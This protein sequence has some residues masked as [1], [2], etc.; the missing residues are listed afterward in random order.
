MSNIFISDVQGSG[1]YSVPASDAALAS[2]TTGFESLL[3]GISGFAYDRVLAWVETASGAGPARTLNCVVEKF[4]FNGEICPSATE[5]YDGAGNGISELIDN[6][7]LGDHGGGN[8][9]TGVDKQ[10]YS[11]TNVAAEFYW[12][13]EFS[14]GFVFPTTTTDD[15]AVGGSSP[16][17]KWFQDGDLVLGGSAMSGTEKLRVVGDVRLDGGMLLPDAAAAPV[18]VSAGQGLFWS[19]DD[20]PNIPKFT[21]DSDTAY[22]LQYEVTSGFSLP[23]IDQVLFVDFAAKPYAGVGT[24][25]GPFNTI[26]E[27]VTAASALSPSASNRIGIVIYPGTYEDNISTTDDYVSFIGFARDSTIIR[28]TTGSTDV[29]NINNDNIRFENLTFDTTGAHTGNVA[30]FDTA[31]TDPTVFVNC[32]FEVCDADSSGTAFVVSADCALEFYDCRFLHVDTTDLAFY[33]SSGSGSILFENCYAQG[34]VRFSGTQEVF[35]SDSSLISGNSSQTVYADSGSSVVKFVHC[36]IENTNSAG[37]C[38]RPQSTVSGWEF[39]G[40][41]MMAGS[42]GYDIGDTTNTITCSVKNTTMQRGMNENCITLNPVKYVGSADDQDF[43]NTLQDAIDSIAASTPSEIILL[44]DVAVTSSLTTGSSQDVTIDGQGRQFDITRATGTV[45]TVS[46]GSTFEL[47]EVKV[48]G[49][50]L[51]DD[52]DSELIVNKGASGSAALQYDVFSGTSIDFDDVYLQ[53]TKVFHGSLGSN[54]PFTG[55]GTGGTPP[56]CDYAAHD[57]CFN[58]EPDVADSTYLNNTIASAQR[59]NT[60]DVN[61]D[62][63]WL[64]DF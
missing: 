10:D 25:Q 12:Q 46:G 7:L 1:I 18:S 28:L 63:T 29:L 41:N 43:Y 21:D 45:L 31:G 47:H 54:N 51:I 48:K 64:A 11:L 22:T 40:C 16:T 5:I 58:I 4:T 49:Q 14:Q 15:V 34:Y 38:V 9:I 44:N 56:T 53:Y 59:F 2:A 19:K 55:Q 61:A 30:V 26:S 62:F 32:K 52:N 17:G 36:Y 23:D 3:S 27:A 35:C 20:S 39:L 50:V 60:I 33:A 6:A 57:C 13:R 42:S 24:M 37:Y 8:V